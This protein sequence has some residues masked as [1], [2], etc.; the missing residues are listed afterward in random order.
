MNSFSIL[1]YVAF[2]VASITCF[3]LHSHFGVPLVL[4]ATIPALTGSFLPFK[5]VHKHHPYA[6]IYAG[7]FVGMCSTDTI[8]ALWHFSVIALIGTAL[9]IKT[10]DQFEGFG[11]RLGGIAF[12]SV[13]MF[14]F[15][16]GML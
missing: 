14:V 6:V 11:G 5:T 9:Y 10:I 13:S 8:S 1:L 3:Y 15:I 4:A 2:L 16:K 7:C 12:I